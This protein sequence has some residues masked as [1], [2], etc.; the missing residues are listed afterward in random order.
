VRLLLLAD[1]HLPRRA[2]A[3]PDQVWREVDD[4]DLVVHAGD[5]TST[6]LLDA[7][8]QRARRLLGCW[9]NNDGLELRARLPEVARPTSTS[10]CSATATSRGTPRPGPACG[11]STPA[12]PPTG[13]G[14]RRAPT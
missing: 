5:W 9:G 3:L 14:S 8:E 1:T 13:G 10:W 2:R 12:R 4:A 7:L 6:D 11:C